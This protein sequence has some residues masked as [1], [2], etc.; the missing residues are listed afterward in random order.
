M[1]EDNLERT[2]S[3]THVTPVLPLRPL[4]EH[5]SQDVIV[6]GFTSKGINYRSVFFEAT[7]D[8]EHWELLDSKPSDNL[9]VTGKLLKSTGY[10]EFW[11]TLLKTSC[12]FCKEGG[13]T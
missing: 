13:Q 4:L 3:F 2:Q 7:E 9:Q 8:C 1:S 12:I 10:A 5:H 6:L 11:Q